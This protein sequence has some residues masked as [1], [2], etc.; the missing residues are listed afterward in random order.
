MPRKGQFYSILA[1]TRLFQ[2]ENDYKTTTGSAP[3]GAPPPG[4][5]NANL[6]R[7]YHRGSSQKPAPFSGTPKRDPFLPAGIRQ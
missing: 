5:E 6:F 7:P 3:P 4:A 2:P 1:I